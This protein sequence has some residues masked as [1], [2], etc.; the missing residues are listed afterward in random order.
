MRI[1]ITGGKMKRKK[2]D[3]RGFDTFIAD[4]SR[5]L[6]GLEDQAETLSRLLAACHD[7][8]VDDADLK[9]RMAVIDELYAHADTEEH[10]A[11]RL[12]ELVTDRVYEYESAAVVVPYSSQAQALAFLMAEQGVKQ[13]DLADIASQSAVSEMLNGK[14]KMTVAQLKRFSEFFAVPAEFFLRGVD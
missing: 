14:R 2:I 8:I 1:A 6:S 9:E 7:R 5:L 13:K 11:A 12:A 3:V 4:M 10:V